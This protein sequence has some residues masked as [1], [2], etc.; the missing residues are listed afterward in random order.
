MEVYKKLF[1]FFSLQ[2]VDRATMSSR[3]AAWLAALCLLQPWLCTATVLNTTVGRSK[4]LMRLS[5]GLSAQGS[6]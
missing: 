5:V 3:L 6:C 4:A 2:T 1:T